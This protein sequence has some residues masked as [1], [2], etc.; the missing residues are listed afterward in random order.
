MRH[1]DRSAGQGTLRF[2]DRSGATTTT[3]TARDT[4]PELSVVAAGRVMAWSV[5]DSRDDS[6]SNQPHRRACY[7]VSYTA[8]MEAMGRSEERHLNTIATPEALAGDTL[9]GIRR[10]ALFIYPFISLH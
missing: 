6:V 3:L 10:G 9:D 5:M 7:Q 8:M 1:R 2:R 4:R